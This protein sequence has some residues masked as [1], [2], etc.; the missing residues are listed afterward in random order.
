DASR[1]RRPHR[2]GA[3]RPGRRRRRVRRSGHLRG[4]PRAARHDGVRGALGGGPAAG[5][6]HRLGVPARLR[7]G[8]PTDRSDRGHARSGSGAHRLPGRL[9][10]RLARDRCRLRPPLHGRRPHAAGRRGRGAGSGDAG[11]GRRPLPS[12][13]TQRPA[14]HRRRG[15]GAR[16][17]GRPPVRRRRPRLRIL[18]RHLLDQ[19]RRRS[20]ARRGH[21]HRAEPARA[22]LGPGREEEPRPGSTRGAPVLRRRGRCAGGHAG[23]ASAGAGRHAGAGPRPGHRRQ[24]V[25]LAAGDRRLRPRRP[26]AGPQPHRRDPAAGGPVLAR[27]RRAGRRRGVAAAGAGPRRRDPGLRDRGPGGAGARPLRPVAPAGQCGG[28]GGVLVPQP[29]GGQPAGAP[30]GDG[31]DPGLGGD[32]G[33]LL[34]RQRPHRGAG[35]HP[36]L[37]PDHRLRRLAA[38]CGA[39][40]GALPRGAPGRRRRSRLALAPLERGGRRRGR[41]GAGVRRL[42]GDVPVGVGLAPQPGGNRPAAAGRSGRRAD[43][44]AGQR[45]AA[46]RHRR[47]RPRG[48]QRAAGRL[49]HGRQA[50]RHQRAD[51][52]RAAALLRRAVRPAGSQGGLSR[53][54]QPLRGVHPH[55]PRGRA[56]PAPDD[57]PR[58]CDLLPGGRSGGP[59]G[60]PTRRHGSGETLTDEAELGRRHRTPV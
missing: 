43:V 17:R 48:G 20:G 26:A 13:Q 8:A 55:P 60:L 29:C 3:A 15:P 10:H 44:D 33:Q 30:R 53:R 50:G 1:W 2:S 58:R 9:R 47:R 45:G 18:A 32:G 28:G 36:D 16:Q 56:H 49:A 52:H 21:P 46:R 40:A 23:A 59:G 31:V 6:A 25:G 35:R 57:L 19:P 41:D 12:P 4:G 38:G 24:P 39:R 42:R 14:R 11:P 27:A 51:H 37:R 54:Q 5:C 34:R 7:G 22:R